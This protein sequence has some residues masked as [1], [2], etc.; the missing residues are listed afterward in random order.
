MEFTVL[1][2]PRGFQSS[3]RQRPH[4]YSLFIRF[5]DPNHLKELIVDPL[6]TNL[7]HSLGSMPSKLSQRSSHSRCCRLQRQ[8]RP[9]RR[10]DS[11]WHKRARIGR[12]CQG[13]RTRTQGTAIPQPRSL[14]GFIVIVIIVVV[15]VVVIVTAVTTVSPPLSCDL[16]DCCV[17]VCHRV[18]SP[19]SSGGGHPAHRI[20]HFRRCRR[21]CRGR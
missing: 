2:S 21:R 17:F 18:L 14:R 13:T 11:S 20:R 16:F 15:V 10:R 12:R 19:S 1:N 5:I 9:P 8:H 3:L 7:H 6:V 4:L